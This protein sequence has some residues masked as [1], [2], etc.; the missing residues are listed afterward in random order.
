MLLPIQ[1]IQM[2]IK[3]KKLLLFLNSLKMNLV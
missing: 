1:L 3:V 2:K